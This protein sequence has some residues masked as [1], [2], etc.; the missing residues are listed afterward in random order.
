MSILN[1][2]PGNP[3]LATPTKDGLLSKSDK[4]KLDS[5]EN[6]ANNYI[7]PVSHP[8]SMITESDT[9]QFV[10][11]E[12]KAKI[13]STIDNATPTENGLMS[14][15]DKAKLDSIEDYANNYTHP[16]SHPASII[17]Q[18]DK[19]RFVSDEQ[20]ASWDGKASTEI[21]EANTKDGLMSKEDKA[22]LDGI[23]TGANK[24]IHP[25]THDAG[26]I[27]QDATH[28]FVTDTEKATWNN[29]ADKT[30]AT[31]E[32]DGLMSKT[33]KSKLDG[34]AA[35][36]NNYIH[37]D[38]HPA[39]MITEDAT[40]RFVSDAEKTTWNGKASTDVAT[41][42]ANGL[43]SKED[44]AKLNG[45]EDN[46]NNYVHPA[47][48]PA[49]MITED[50]SHRFITD[51]ERISWN[52]KPGGSTATSENDGLMSKEDKV[53]LD[54]IEEGANNYIHPQNHPATMIIED[55]THRFVSD[56]EKQSWNGKP[57]DKIDIGLGNV[58]NDAQVKRT[59]MGVANGVATLDDTG[60]VPSEQ[61]PSFVDDVLEYDNFEAFPPTGESG[62]IYVDKATNTTYRWSGTQ[63]TSIGNSLSLGETESTAYPGNKGKANADEIAKIKN[64]TTIV[65]KAGD[66]ATVTG[67]TVAIDVPA[68][69]KFTDTVYTH[70][71]THPATIIDQDTTH[72]F[73]SDTEKSTWNAKA[74][75]AVVTITAN[76][77]MSKED[78]VKLN[79]IEEGANNYVHPTN[80]A[81]TMITED[82]THRFTTDEE[83]AN[84]NAKAST[85]IA[86]SAV[87]GLMSKEDKAKLDGI[88]TGANNYVHPSTH[89]ASMIT[90]TSTSRF[91]SDA[92]INTWN[93]KADTT[94]VSTTVNGL[95]S[96][97]DKVK[98]DSI[99]SGANKYVHPA[100][101]PASI[102]EQDSS[103]RF[104]TDSEKATWNAKADKNHKHVSLE[105]S[106]L[107]KST[108]P[109]PNDVGFVKNTMSVEL[110]TNSLID[111]PPVAGSYSA[112]MN[113]APG[114]DQGSGNGYQFLFGAGSTNTTPS[115]CI[116]TN[117]L[118]G[119][120]WGPWYELYTTA[121]KPTP[122]DIGAAT[123]SHTHTASSIT[124]DTSHRFV[125]DTEKSTWNAK[126]ST[127]VVT[128]S[129]N[130][131]MIAADK[132]KLDGIAVNAN[133]YVHPANHP[134]TMIT[135]DTTHRFVT[136]TQINTWNA[137]A[138][139]SLAT[140]LANGLMSKEDKAKLDSI[141]SGANK[142]VHPSTHPATMITEDTTHRF[143]TDSEKATWN[144]KADTTVASSTKNGLMSSTDK[145][146]LT[147]LD[148]K[149][150]T[151]ESNYAAMLAKLKTAVFIE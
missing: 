69:A 143:V 17:A 15:E 56:A 46:A 67:H 52:S 3:G 80:H 33:D 40:H 45:I 21:A 11:K 16:V 141:A 13:N 126:A 74:S 59:E 133:N 51:E 84:W 34:I 27:T 19:M 108:N 144:A 68:N 129:A 98:L 25:S 20:I 86:T 131:L 150:K 110:K 64:G 79:G 78:K 88:S 71:S 136:D 39:T 30:V 118:N 149:V 57:D 72:R 42:A 47:N 48:H 73:V 111:N 55:V 36:A 100:T 92:Q 1:T 12:E 125:T 38:S 28:R 26:M 29:K 103:N 90:T 76:G 58:T 140:T 9:R 14:K 75:T 61:L 134:A 37:P 2:F 35:N 43:M 106:S 109:S 44:K 115:L 96:S 120:S 10:T 113:V 66:A 138:S 132:K 130:G 63:Y 127:A 135:Q 148:S 23:E 116:R 123:A 65:P 60:K 91:V 94:L 122:A 146:T 31:I 114:E 81:A 107:N 18:N 89:P 139:T 7:H 112:V 95:M 85:T 93:S 145:N 102:I 151:L 22:K 137:K 62:K 119:T 105:I 77:L 8:A 70:P 99:A 117:V 49:T 5:V 87:N 97:V 50:A 104:V 121:N 54:A 83:K 4:Q 124:E 6:G 142:Y 128:Q 101:H 53:K 82:E 32:N 41:T 147:S 24:Y